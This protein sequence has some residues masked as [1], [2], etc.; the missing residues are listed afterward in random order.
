MRNI[1]VLIPDHAF[2][3]TCLAA[4]EA[5][6]YQRSSSPVYLQSLSCLQLNKKTNI[7]TKLDVKPTLRSV[8]F[9]YFSPIL[10]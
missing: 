7:S 10:V 9:K 8:G 2:S 5:L 6:I 4:F 1:M 3:C